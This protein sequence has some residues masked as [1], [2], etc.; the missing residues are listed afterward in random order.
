MVVRARRVGIFAFPA[1]RQFARIKD[2]VTRDWFVEH[3][4]Q[5]QMLSV[6]LKN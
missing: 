5:S 4:D 1:F 2:K 6:Y 3:V